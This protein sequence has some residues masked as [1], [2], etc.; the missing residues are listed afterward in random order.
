M[1]RAERATTALI[2]MLTSGLL[3][4]SHPTFVLRIDT[5]RLCDEPTLAGVTRL[6]RRHG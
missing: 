2:G 5:S 3:Y 4:P 1:N 6:A